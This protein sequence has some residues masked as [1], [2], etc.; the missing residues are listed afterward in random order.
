MFTL[1]LNQVLKGTWETPLL[2]TF[3]FDP[4]P[5]N[6]PRLVEVNGYKLEPALLLPE[7]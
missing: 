2:C 5:G 3:S 1:D 6:V 7:E 4:G